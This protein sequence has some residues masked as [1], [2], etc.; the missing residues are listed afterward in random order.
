MGQIYLF[1]E[2]CEYWPMTTQT[3][4]TA[5][6]SPRLVETNGIQLAVHEQG[7]G[8]AVILLHGFPELAY[9][10]RHQLPALAEAGYRA[11]APDQRGYGGSDKPAHVSD[12]G[13]DA[14]IADVDGLLDALDIPEAIFIGHDWG[15]LV[16]W[17]K[18]L[19]DPSR[20]TGIINL[21]IPFHPAPASD[22]ID[23][24]RGLLGD[25]FYIV[26]FQDSD[27][28]DRVFAADVS[29]FFRMM[30]RREQ[31]RRHQFDALPPEKKI[32]SLLATMAREES[33][34]TPLLGEAELG[35]FV[36]AFKQGGFTGPINWYRNWSNNWLR[37]KDLRQIVTVPTLFIGAEDDVIVAPHHIDAMKPHIPDLE[38]QSI[39]RCGHWTQ[40]EH[41]DQ[42]NRIILEWLARRYPR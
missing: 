17:M 20:M 31:I 37:T 42:V 36:D 5:F 12:Y 2:I 28:A 6:P 1:S 15:A 7:T 11:I 41:P 35:V 10:W 38:I 25:E 18:A 16:L 34:G 39:A 30:M 29:H 14:L 33:N 27:E 8:P 13:I 40:Q 4:V 22:P 21:N 32:L 9:S 19:I 3:D 24:M 23:L 26:N